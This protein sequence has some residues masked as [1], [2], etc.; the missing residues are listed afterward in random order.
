MSLVA[1]SEDNTTDQNAKPSTTPHLTSSIS[2]IITTGQNFHLAISTQ[3]A[4]PASRPIILSRSEQNCLFASSFFIFGLDYVRTCFFSMLHLFAISSSQ[5]ASKGSVEQ[6]T[7]P[8]LVVWLVHNLLVALP[9]NLPATLFQFEHTINFQPV[10]LFHIYIYIH[11][12]V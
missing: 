4:L 3:G 10:Q 12:L 11:F 5:C 1:A 7:N 6:F 9:A 2:T 8:I